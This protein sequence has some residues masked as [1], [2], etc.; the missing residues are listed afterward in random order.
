VHY[1][2]NFF[3]GLLLCNCIPHLVAGLQGIAFPTPFAKPPAAGNSPPVINFLW[4]F[5]NLLLG[6]MLLLSHWTTFADAFD[7]TFLLLGSF[8]IGAHL[9]IH[10]GKVRRERR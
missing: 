1:I 8:V 5:L 2:A 6:G 9:S 7:W 3:A 10:F 4:G